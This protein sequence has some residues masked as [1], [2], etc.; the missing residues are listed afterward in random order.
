MEKDIQ[1]HSRIF[2]VERLKY[3]TSQCQEVVK[4]VVRHPGSVAVLPV[5]DDGRICLIRNHRV[6]VREI[7]LEIPAGTMEPPEPPHECAHRELIEETGYRAAKI[8]KLAEFYPAPGILDEKMHAFIATGLQP[9]AHA[10]EVGEEIE[11]QIVSLDQAMS[12][13]ESGDIHDAKTMLALLL[14]EKNGFPGRRNE[15]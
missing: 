7:L 6:S 8:E 14:F 11:N 2:H 12:M 3:E 15:Q 13:I 5:L 1:F 10:R 4:D 9:G